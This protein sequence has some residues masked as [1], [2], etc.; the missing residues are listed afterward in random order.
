MTEKETRTGE[1][2]G[3]D[4]LF[5]ISL[6]IGLSIF[7]LHVMEPPWKANLFVL[8]C[9]SFISLLITATLVFRWRMFGDWRRTSQKII[10][11]LFFLTLVFLNTGML[12]PTTKD[13]I[14]PDTLER[15]L[16]EIWAFGKDLPVISLIFDLMYGALGFLYLFLTLVLLTIGGRVL[17]KAYIFL[18][19]LFSIL[20]SFFLYPRVEMALAGLYLIVFLI[21]QFERPLMIS[22]DV[23]RSLNVVQLRY[24]RR[25]LKDQSLTTGE[26][27]LFLDN[28]ADYFA[29][30]LDHKLVEY[31]KETREIVP[32][33][34]LIHDKSTQR[35]EANISL[36]QRLVWFLVGLLYFIMPDLIPGPLDD[37]IILTICSLT[38]SNFFRLLTRTGAPRALDF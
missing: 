15:G 10:Y 37:L 27:K 14:L 30:L 36:I 13:T 6:L 26:T 8:A 1:L 22:D 9:S 5:R 2:P 38:G 4:I 33:N 11:V 34:R 3:P 32:G 20:L 31:D 7:L 12:S 29:E 18:F 23:R 21:A 17:Q 19:C 35:V 24:L 28:Q 25:L 16:G